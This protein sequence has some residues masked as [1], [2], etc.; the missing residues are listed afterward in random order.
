ME[1]NWKLFWNVVRIAFGAVILVA[2]FVLLI[3][4]LFLVSGVDIACSL[5]A[6]FSLILGAI[7]LLFG[8]A[9]L[10]EEK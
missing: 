8:I 2:A 5:F 7:M 10:S 3:Y 1:F 6:F 9:A 4:S